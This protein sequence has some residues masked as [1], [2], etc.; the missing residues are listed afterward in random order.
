MVNET[1]GLRSKFTPDPVDSKAV[2][3][4]DPL[5]TRCESFS[6]NI[7]RPLPVILESNQGGTVNI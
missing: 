5:S 7:V 4:W 1:F 6:H 3:K 2:M